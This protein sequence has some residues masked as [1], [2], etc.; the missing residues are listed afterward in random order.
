METSFVFKGKPITI[1]AHPTPLVLT[2]PTPLEYLPAPPPWGTYPPHPPGVLTRPTP[3][4]YLPAPP[5]WGTYPPR[6]PGVLTYLPRPPGVLTRPTPLGYLPALPPGVLTRPTPLGVPMYVCIYVSVFSSCRDVSTLNF[7]LPTVEDYFRDLVNRVEVT[8]YNR[9]D[10]SDPG[11]TLILNQ[12]MTYTQVAVAVADYI[13][14]DMKF[15]QFFK[16]SHL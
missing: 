8:F 13:K 14:E 3:L 10:S 11:F 12:K 5:P 16:P 1:P 9:S 6:P 15:I 4:G 7:E 2:R